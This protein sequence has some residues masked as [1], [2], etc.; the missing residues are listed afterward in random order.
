MSQKK[1]GSR[2]PMSEER[3]QLLRNLRDDEALRIAS[4]FASLP[5]EAEIRKPVVTKLKGY[6]SA[7]LYRE[8]DRGNFP[9]PI[10]RSARVSV[11]RVGDVRRALGG[12]AT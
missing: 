5:P 7:T 9:A 3:K 4:I 1:S 11:W 8:I 2:G 10:K 6:S 12:E